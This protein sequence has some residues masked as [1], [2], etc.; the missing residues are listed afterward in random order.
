MAEGVVPDLVPGAGEPLHRGTALGALRCVAGDEERAATAV[1]LEL[2][3]D[4]AGPLRGPSSNV[5]AT[6]G[7]A[8]P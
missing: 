5:S 1:T 7:V 6:T 2:V 8:I 3:G 4:R